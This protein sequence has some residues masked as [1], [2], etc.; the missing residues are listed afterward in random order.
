MYFIYTYILYLAWG[1]EVA[2]LDRI[3]YINVCIFK[4]L[5]LYGTRVLCTVY[6]VIKF[7][8]THGTGY[9]TVP[10]TGNSYGRSI[11]TIGYKLERI[12]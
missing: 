7:T 5:I 8:V 9:C 2:T 11:Y 12:G 6:T 1:W 4:I 10:G 3:G